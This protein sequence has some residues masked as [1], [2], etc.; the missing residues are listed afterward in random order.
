MDE[1]LLSL[2][3]ASRR[4]V[5]LERGVL[6]VTV[7]L[8]S[9]LF[10]M[11]FNHLVNKSTE[12]HCAVTM[13]LCVC[14]LAPRAPWTLGRYSVLPWLAWVRNLV[15]PN[16]QPPDGLHAC[17]LPCPQ[18]GLDGGPYTSVTGTPSSLSPA[19]PEQGVSELPRASE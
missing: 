3:F 13:H 19:S 2:G 11:R 18:E 8:L 5:Q 10:R 9:L 12:T 17:A 15:R 14:Q 6:P 16:P 7:P 4:W 1:T